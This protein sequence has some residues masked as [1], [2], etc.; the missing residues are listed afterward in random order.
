MYAAVFDF[1]D[2]NE[3]DEEKRRKYVLT[4]RN[5]VCLG[6]Y[7]K[8]A[9]QEHRKIGSKIVLR[10]GYLEELVCNDAYIKVNAWQ[11]QYGGQVNSTSTKNVAQLF[12]SNSERPSVISL[13]EEE[14]FIWD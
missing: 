9:H 11:S 8:R 5:D 10:V 1:L 4:I 2:L 3:Q 13:M 6:D 7:T 14:E 12:F